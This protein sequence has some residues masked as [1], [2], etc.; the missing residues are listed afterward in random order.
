M[1][2]PGALQG[3]QCL[4]HSGAQ[5]LGRLNQVQ[6]LTSVTASAIQQ[7]AGQLAS[8]GVIMLQLLHS[9]MQDGANDLALLIGGGVRTS[10]DPP[11]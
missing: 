11:L 6:Q 3:L 2:G 1:A 7:H 4:L 8:S 10:P 9:A 5:L